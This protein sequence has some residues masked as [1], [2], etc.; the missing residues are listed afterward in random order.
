MLCALSKQ[1]QEAGSLSL[2]K[3]PYYGVWDTRLVLGA[4]LVQDVLH[5]QA[6]KEESVTHEISSSTEAFYNCKG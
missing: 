4:T 2:A 3:V 5:S 6:S 1:L